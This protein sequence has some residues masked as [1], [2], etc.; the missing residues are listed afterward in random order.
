LNWVPF[1]LTIVLAVLTFAF[2][3]SERSVWLTWWKNGQQY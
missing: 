1:I 2:I 3:V